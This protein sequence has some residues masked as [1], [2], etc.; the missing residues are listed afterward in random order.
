MRR[1]LWLSL[2]CAAG[3]VWLGWPP[4]AQVEEFDHATTG[5]PLTGAHANAA[6]ES[7][8]VHGTFKG[9]PRQCAPCHTQGGPVVAS[10][11]SARHILTATTCEDC[12]TTTAWSPVVRVDHG[13]VMGACGACHNGTSAG[14]QPATHIST[15][16]VCESC[17]RTSTWS[18]VTRVDH[19]VVIG[20]CYSCHN[21]SV[22]VGKPSNHINTANTCD[23]CHRTS[24]WSPV[25][26]VDHTVVVG[27]CF[28]CHNN[29][30]AGGKRP[31]HIV[32]PN[33]CDLCHATDSWS[34]F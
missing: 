25:V 21:S 4:R 2:I 30:V 32:S 34:I 26:Q 22:T 12:H 1:A 15:A 11:R 29:V 13:V 17:H 31:G 24:T 20:T 7:C 23:S 6:C 27:T 28:S 33:T 10:V 8:H 9:A 16:G 5:F 14:G 19:T 3:L 18:P